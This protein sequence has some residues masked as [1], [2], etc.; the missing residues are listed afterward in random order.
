M[1][2][3]LSR[4]DFLK[5]L[6]ALCVAALTPLPLS[7]CRDEQEVVKVQGRVPPQRQPSAGRSAPSHPDLAVVTGDTPADITR[8]AIETLGGMQRFVRAGDKIVV[9]PN[10][11]CSR[12]PHYAVT[13]N[14]DVIEAIVRLCVAAGANDVLVIDRPTSGVDE[15]YRVTGIGAAAERGGGRVRILG[16]RDFVDVAIPRGVALTQWPVARDVLDADVLIN[17][18]IA[19]HHSLTGVTLGIKNLMGII[20]GNRGQLHWGIDQ[21]LADLSTLIAPQLTIVDAN[22]V[23][24]RN[25]PSGG[26]LD[27]VKE[28]KTVV[29]GTDPVLVDSYATTLFGMKPADI[30][31]IAKAEKMGLGSHDLE[32]SDIIRIAL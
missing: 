22:R 31:H 23:L 3:Q 5:T 7:G 11:L 27:D 15:A 8:K 30:A 29:A 26:S 17:V 1:Q 10:I 32:K 24:V 2:T 25:G 6:A 16:E 4:K 12:E 9:K 19:K 14:P 13:T 28:M 20:G 18:P 21:K